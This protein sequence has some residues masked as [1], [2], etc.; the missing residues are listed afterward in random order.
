M[1]RP[2]LHVPDRTLDATRSVVLREGV[3]GATIAAIAGESGQ[4]V[5]SLYHAFGSRDAILAATWRRAVERS[6]EAWLAGSRTDDPV[7]RGV[8]MALGLITFARTDTEDARLLTAV[9]AEDLMSDPEDLKEVNA[10]VTRALAVL[11]KDLSGRDAAL[12]AHLATVEIPYGV[13]RLRL[14]DEQPLL[15]RSLESHVARAARAVLEPALP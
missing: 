2:L 6:H 15:P 4:S 10:L 8:A 3:R 14:R 12:R 5:G 13:L 1:P 7:D 9:R 11:A